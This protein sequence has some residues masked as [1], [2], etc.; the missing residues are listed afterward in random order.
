MVR[1]YFKTNKKNPHNNRIEYYILE[2]KGNNPGNK[3]SWFNKADKNYW[4]NWI[5]EKAALF[6]QWATAKD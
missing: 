6:T 4:N 3:N 5:E 1:S 2:E